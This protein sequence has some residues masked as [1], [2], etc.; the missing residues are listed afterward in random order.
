MQW[1]TKALR[2][3]EIRK[4]VVATMLASKTLL[5]PSCF[6]NSN[7]MLLVLAVFSEKCPQE[8]FVTTQVGEICRHV[9]KCALPSDENVECVE[10]PPI[11][12]IELYSELVSIIAI[13]T[14]IKIKIMTKAILM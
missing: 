5:A 3:V 7:D 13:K 14:I 1:E 8:R 11:T 12:D 6:S 2:V 10:S 4:C 9:R